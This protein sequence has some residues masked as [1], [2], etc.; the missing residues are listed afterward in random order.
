MQCNGNR[1]WHLCQQSLPTSLVTGNEITRVQQWC[2]C[3]TMSHNL[4]FT[5]NIVIR[6]L[7]DGAYFNVDLA[8]ISN[9][10]F[11][12][13]GN[14]GVV[15]ESSVQITFANNEISQSG[16]DGLLRIGSGL[17]TIVNGVYVDN[18]G[19][20][21]FYKYDVGSL[22]HQN[23]NT[24]I[25]NGEILFASDRHLSSAGVLT[26]VDVDFAISDRLPFSDRGHGRR[27]AGHD[28]RRLV[29]GAFRAREHDE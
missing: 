3:S 23:R 11:G 17:V 5:W 20:T 15:F 14:V 16:S 4:V 18:G 26:L 29:H 13:S 7:G 12:R 21:F 10:V 22:D 1:I 19:Y 8:T 2:S 9:N 6:S 25:M 28:K 27:Q 24:T